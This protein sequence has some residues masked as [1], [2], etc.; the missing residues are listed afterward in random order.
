MNNETLVA[1]G[2]AVLTPNYRQAPVALVRGEG[3]RVWDA[4]GRE[5][6]DCICGI[7]VNA[8]GHCHPAVVAALE[9]QARELW[10][11]SNLFFNPRAVEL[12]EALVE[13]SLFAR[14]VFFC[15]SGAEANEAML[16]LARKYQADLGHPERNE[17]V[18]CLSSFH[19]RTMFALS[20]TGQEKYHHGFEPLVPGVRHVPYGDVEA[21]RGALGPRTAAFIVE[22]IQGEAGVMPAPEGYL[23]RA[24]AL[25]REAGALLCFDEVQTGVGRT[26]RMWAH[27][28]DGV[29]PDLMSSA[30]AIA[31][32]FPMGALLASEEVG[33][34]L[35]PGSH[36]ST[37]GGNALGC[38]AALAVLKVLRGGA[39]EAS[40]AVSARLVERLE[41]LRATGRVKGVRGRGMLQGVLLQGVSA[42]AVVELAR[43]QGLLVNA[44]G[45]SV[46]RFAP[47]LTLTA[48]EAD[49]AAERLGAALRAAP[50]K[51]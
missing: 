8:L 36:A 9:A 46:I 12:A 51:E 26:G 37:F 11:V 44:I 50:A 6:L 13:G 19:G 20:C 24:R 22:P 21:L 28:W 32:G 15:N 41:A 35:T 17:I 5:Y 1:R 16:K 29:A 25:T 30:K 38:A 2:K 47:A 45:D 40:R 4:D 43:A 14:R 39:L 42:G 23:A 33:A 49:L 18:A 48:A 34:H 10:H 3:S 27:E 7:A 31:N